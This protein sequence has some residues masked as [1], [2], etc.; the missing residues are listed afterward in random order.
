M[1][2]IIQ[3]AETGHYK[4]GKARDYREALKR[5]LPQIAARRSNDLERS[6]TLRLV[7]WLDWPS[8][9]EMDLHRYMWRLWVGDEWF[10]DGPEL[11]QLLAWA[12]D[13]GGG[14]YAFL[15]ALSAA[16]ALPP[17]WNWRSRDRL[18]ASHL[19]KMSTDQDTE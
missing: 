16:T 6:C 3:E 5:R 1:I 13:R 17:R 18:L 14:Y 19:A 4:V 10:T 11:R 12:D 8:D 2:Y 7:R 15:K 9:A